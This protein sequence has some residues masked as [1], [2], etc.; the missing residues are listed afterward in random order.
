MKKYRKETDGF[1]LGPIMIFMETGSSLKSITK[2]LTKLRMA[3]LQ[4]ETNTYHYIFLYEIT[5]VY[6]EIKRLLST[7]AKGKQFKLS[8][9]LHYQ[10]A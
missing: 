10:D 8:L 5:Q 7:D 3:S 4:V 6:M 2:I 9:S 1:S